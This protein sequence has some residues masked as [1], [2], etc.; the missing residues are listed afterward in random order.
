[1]TSHLTIRH[2]PRLAECP[3]LM[4]DGGLRNVE[5]LNDVVDAY[6]VPAKQ[7]KNAE[8]SWIGKPFQKSHRFLKDLFTGQI[9]TE[10]AV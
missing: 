2:Q 8:P 7:T 5:R 4:T 10:H 1:M 9:M 6:L 3:K